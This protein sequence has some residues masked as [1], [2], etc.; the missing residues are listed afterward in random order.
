MNKLLIFFS[1]LIIIIFAGIDAN[2]MLMH[3][4]IAIK[5]PAQVEMQSDIL[6]PTRNATKEKLNPK[7]PIEK[8]P[9]SLFNERMKKQQNN[10]L[11]Q[12]KQKNNN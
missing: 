10:N 7:Q 6:K 11:P 2:N 9:N 5:T 12:V 1:V 8:A 3:Q 4:E